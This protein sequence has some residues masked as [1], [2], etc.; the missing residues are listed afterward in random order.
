[1]K[2]VSF[3]LILIATAAI[4][5]CKKKGC[6]DETASNYSEE[7]KKDDGSCTYPELA[8]PSTYNF[9]DDAGNNTVS[10]GGQEERLNQ[11]EEMTTYMKSGTA[12]TL[13]AAI[14]T[15]M[16]E[17][18]DDNASGN[19]TFA[20]TKQLKNKCFASDVTRFEGYLT[21]LALASED[22]SEI[23]SSGQAGVLSSGTSTYL[24]A[25]NGIEYA[26]L[27]EKGLMGAVFLNQALNVYFGADKM[28][29]DNSTAVNTGEGKFYTEMEHHWDEAFG[30]FGAP[31]DFPTNTD[32]LRFW[33]KY[34]DI[35]SAELNPSL[36][37]TNAFLKGR[38]AISQGFELSIRDE[39]IKNIREEWERLSAAQA[40]NYLEKAKENFG[41]DNAKFL[42]ELSEAYA[43]ILCLKY[44]PLE[45]RTIDYADIETI[46]DD[47]ITTDF[48]TVTISDLNVSITLLN[49]T[50]GF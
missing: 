45:T 19:F 43:F 16:F 17:N 1:M 27:I 23:A 50:Y 42:H 24:F 21:A 11:L 37:I 15:A 9:T 12:A 13:N 41:S 46:L 33:A 14:L 25:A 8:I 47:I 32:N 4:V 29:V 34:Y 7:A 36:V 26:Q 35:Q 44:V 18:T 38:A 48:W 28:N 31:I 22:H 6:T 20:S 49:D 30:Y 10:Y 3:L 39:Q 40:V 2:N 5:S